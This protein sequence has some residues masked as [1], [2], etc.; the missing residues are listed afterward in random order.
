MVRKSIFGIPLAL[1]L[2]VAVGCGSNQAGV[3][4]DVTLGG[5]PIEGGS[6]SFIPTD[7][8]AGPPAHGKIEGGH[9]SI[10][11]RDGPAI[12]TSRVEIRW[13]RKTGRKIPAIA[14]APKGSF[15]EETIE[16]VPPRYNSKSELEVPV[17]RG[18]NTF[19]FKLDL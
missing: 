13:T 17:E 5:Q 18:D 14:P 19:D 11:A 12:G 10:A 7:S 8:T 4:G 15:T 16:A 3:S 9:Y 1:L 6:I 2:I